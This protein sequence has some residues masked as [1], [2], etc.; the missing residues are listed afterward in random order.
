[1]RDEP[2]HAVQ[3]LLA[4]LT[5][6]APHL[7]SD[8][9]A[10]LWAAVE[11]KLRPAPR[12]PAWLALATLGAAAAAITLLAT[13]PAPTQPLDVPLAARPLPS[14]AWVETADAVEVTAA[15]ANQTHLR[16]T[17][18]SLTSRVPH[19][20]PGQRYLVET[21]TALVEVRG[22][23]FTVAVDAAGATTVTVDEGRVEVTPTGRAPRDARAGTR[24]TVEAP[25][26]AGAARAEAR[27]DV[28]EALDIQAHLLFSAPAGL[29]RDN[30]LLRLGAV[31]DARLPQAAPA[32]WDRVA[33]GDGPHA[34]V[35]SFR[36]ADA[37]R[38]LGQLDAARAAAA[39]FRAR[40]PQSPRAVET[41]RW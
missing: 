26:A 5:R 29:A 21:P 12:W 15:T 2:D 3:R 23:V 11:P 20:A 27:G 13:R 35:A 37:L 14:G 31:Y 19:L 1:M 18:G 41:T 32:F 30:G 17:T 6:Q 10:A 39:A 7:T 25:T 40:F 34:E 33:A 22:T 24:L 9:E 28:A 38:R 4:P 16:L 8:R 36:H